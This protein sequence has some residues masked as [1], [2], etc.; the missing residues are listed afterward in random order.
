MTRW[1]MSALFGVMISCGSEPAPIRGIETR[2]FVDTTDARVGDPVGVTVE[3]ETPEGYAIETP[4]APPSDERFFTERIETLDSMGIPGGVRHR[5]LWTLR[6]RSVGEHPLP[7]LEIPLVSP[8]G[9][10]QPLPVGGVPL[11]VGSV[12]AEL[13]EREVFFDIRPP[14]TIEE[15]PGWIWIATGIGFAGLLLG[16]LLYRR[17]HPLDSAEP[18]PPDAIAREALAKLDAAL[19]ETDSRR[20]AREVDSVLRTFTERC[21]A[22]SGDAWTPDELPERVDTEVVRALR[23]LE[24]NRFAREPIRDSVLVTV[25]H[26][27]AYLSHVAGRD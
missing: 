13:P 5:L 21:W 18:K 20:L 7:K 19:A 2:V 8:D 9:R 4:A 27:H 3:I 1:G 26:L 23:D 24:A 25:Q 11:P 14:P 17:K 6:A 10:I 16:G 15:G 22:V 12:R